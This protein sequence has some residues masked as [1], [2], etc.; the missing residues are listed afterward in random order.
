M[1]QI[2][3]KSNSPIYI[4]MKF[5]GSSQC[6][7][8]MKVIHKK[9]TEYISDVDNNKT[10]KKVILVIS[11][12]GKTTNNLYGIINFVQGSYE[13][14]YDTHKQLCESININFDE[15][16]IFLQMLEKDMNDYKLTPFVNLIQQKLKIISWGEILASKI[17]WLYL[18]KNGISS[19]YL[20]AHLFI[21]ND[22]MSSN[23][24]RDT[25]NLKGE[26]Y[27][28]KSVLTNMIQSSNVFVTQGFV[29]TTADNAYCVLTRSG[30]NTSASLIANAV[31]AEKLEIFTDVSGIYSGDPR[32]I[33]NTQ[34]IPCARYDVCLEASSMGTNIIHPFSIRPCLEKNIPIYIKNTFEPNSTGTVITSQTKCRQ[35]S[36]YL[37]S[38]QN[39]VTIFKIYSLNMSEGH[40]FMADIFGIFGNEKMDVGIVTT[41]Q[42]EVTAT[43]N[44]KN[45]AKI[46]RT[47]LALAESYQVNVITN[48]AIVSIIAENVLYNKKIDKARRLVLEKKIK[49]IHISVPSS[50]NLTWSFVV[51][52]NSSQELASLLHEYFIFN[53]DNNPIF[54]STFDPDLNLNNDN[55]KTTKL[56]PKKRKLN[57]TI[58]NVQFILTQKMKKVKT[59]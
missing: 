15:I 39:S 6:L 55:N 24:D 28:D 33:A 8:G 2:I 17:V 11:A 43:T 48:C 5:G 14:I 16:K 41:S 52:E 57:D 36:V 31:D 1:D 7:Q 21:K 26:F 3:V 38:I 58:T 10:N 30:S 27:C 12:V 29:A 50:N 22:N 32:K 23:I 45:I 44:E 56:S 46:E 59:F 19:E 4:V 13:T 35:S 47:K 54:N 25:L 34:V 9:I 53:A 40:G 18:N 37:I 49:P 42:F 20:Q 51:D